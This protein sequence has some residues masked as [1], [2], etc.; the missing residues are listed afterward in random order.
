M[1]RVDEAG[2]PC[3]ATL[4]E[5]RKMCVAIGGE[6]C[7]AVEYL[8]KSI[9]RSPEGADEIVVLP[10]SAMRAALMPACFPDK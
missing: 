2:N 7:A 10:D 6:G 8:D 4:G 1:P 3:P 5:Y 9:A